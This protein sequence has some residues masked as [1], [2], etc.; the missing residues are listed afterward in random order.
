[1]PDVPVTHTP[2]ESILESD[3]PAEDID[4]YVEQIRQ[5]AEKLKL[6]GVDGTAIAADAVVKLARDR[7]DGTRNKRGATSTTSST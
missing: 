6:D 5:T 4:E 7:R 1:M 2:F 3:P